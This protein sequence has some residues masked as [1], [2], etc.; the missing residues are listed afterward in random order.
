MIL[1]ICDVP[2]V[3]KVLRI[4]HIVIRIIR[5]VVPI[6]LIIS[7][8]IDLVHNV[9]DG[10]IE[11]VS[12]KVINKVIAAILIFFIPTFVSILSTLAGNTEYKK[13][14]EPITLNQIYDSFVLN[15]EQLV[16]KA[17]ETLD[18]G[19][20]NSATTYLSNVSDANKKKEFSD[21]LKAV[22]SKID[23][24]NKKDDN[25][26]KSDNEKGYPSQTYGKCEF[27]QKSAAGMTYGLCVPEN[28]TNQN[29]PMIVWLHGSG[30]VGASFKSFYNSGLLTVVNNWSKTGL[31][32]IPAIIVAPQLKSGNWNASSA[33]NG[34]KEIM[35]EVISQY[36]I[37]TN[38]ISLI[39][40]SLG[41]SG[42][43]YVAAANQSYFSSIVVL[44][45]YV[46]SPSSDNMSYFKNIPVKGYS[47]SGTSTSS[48]MRSIGKSD[49]YRQLNCSHGQ[50]P[51]KALELDEDNDGVSDLI[52]WMLSN[53]K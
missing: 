14:L 32:D 19:A 50:V 43:Y 18:I 28:Y 44:S 12:K 13:C 7:V 4:V 1:G 51:R 35:D 33:K 49:Q 52:Y 23:A 37:N 30:E 47:E 2:D 29:I 21:R 8:M 6:I 31:Q 26:K 34:V 27:V 17:E 20:Y 41:G 53:E 11:K 42:V 16:T 3:M 39:G 5:I 38:N 10:E 40:H 9:M 24:S 45:G 15:E 48:F 25:P 46:S 22:K 36:N